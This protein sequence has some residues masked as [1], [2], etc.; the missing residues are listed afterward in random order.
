[1]ATKFISNQQVLDRQKGIA[2]QINRQIT[3]YNT[4][5]ASY[6]GTSYLNKE[7][8]NEQRTL[9]NNSFLFSGDH[10]GGTF[11]KN[12]S[13]VKGINSSVFSELVTIDENINIIF[14]GVTF[15]E[16][17]NSQDYLVYIKK[18]AKVIFQN[19]S[20]IRIDKTKTNLV[21]LV[22]T[23]TAKFV[24]L[25]SPAAAADMVT[26]SGC[27]FVQEADSGANEI[28]GRTGALGNAYVY[29]CIRATTP[30]VAYGPAVVGTGG[31]L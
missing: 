15:V 9:Y 21:G 26:F 16:G 28:V 6:F 8:V 2:E 3:Q 7:N 31:N 23:T 24:M 4:D 25:E 18:G 10:K 1:M 20:F 13:V 19:C 27:M 22:K 11:S 14:D 5:I 17:K 29:N 30:V 12:F